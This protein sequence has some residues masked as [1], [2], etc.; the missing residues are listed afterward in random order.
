MSAT[1]ASKAAGATKTKKKA[2]AANG[3]ED[4]ETDAKEA[5]K[6]RTSFSAIKKS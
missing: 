1:A 4:S 3:V 2:T 6:V 5:K